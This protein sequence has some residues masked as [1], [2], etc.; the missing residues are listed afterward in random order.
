MDE[1]DAAVR[2]LRLWVPVGDGTQYEARLKL[3][4]EQMARLLELVRQ[5]APDSI[6]V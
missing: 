5:K 6:A 4:D 2:E 1:V 3:F